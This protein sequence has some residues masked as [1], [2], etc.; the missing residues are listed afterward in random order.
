MKPV[1]KEERLHKYIGFHNTEE[2]C[3]SE[4]TNKDSAKKLCEDTLLKY[5]HKLQDNLTR[6][7]LENYNGE[8]AYVGSTSLNK[9]EKKW[10]TI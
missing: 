1:K 10:L 7:S 2:V 6:F 4:S 3:N 9:K 8:V 5:F